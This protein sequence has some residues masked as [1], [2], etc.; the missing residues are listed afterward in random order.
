[1]DNG[2]KHG[3]DTTQ[4]SWF[5]RE[6]EEVLQALDTTPEGLTPEEASGRLEKYGPNR[7][8]GTRGRSA[9]SRF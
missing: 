8:T 9:L 4:P 7:L 1:M 2:N 6:S 3:T 5:A